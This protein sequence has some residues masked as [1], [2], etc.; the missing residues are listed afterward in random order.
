[1]EVK[2]HTC[3][4]LFSWIYRISMLLFTVSSSEPKITGCELLE[5]ENL[6]CYWTAHSSGNTSYMMRVN[7]T[8]C[9][10]HIST[11]SCNTTYTQCFVKIGSVSHCFC[12]D[13][14]VFTSSISTRYPPYC[15]NG[16]NE[17]KLYPP[18]ITT[19]ATLP[20]NASCLKLEWKEPRSEY[21]P[22]EKKHRVLQI[23]YHTPQ[24]ANF[25]K[26]NTV[27]HDWQM[28][29]CG[30]Y[31]GTK[32]FVR[33]RAQDLR[34]AN[35]W[36]SWSG[37][38][39]AT[40][41]EAAPV[42]TPEL[43]RH[44]Q[45][46]DRSRQR[47]ITLLWKPLLW[48]HTNG[49][50]VR[51]AAACWN[52]PDSSYWDCGHLESYSTFCVLSVS[53]HACNCNLTAFNSAGKSPSAHIYI[54]GDRDA[55]L[56]PP[57]SI[58]VNSL[59]DFQLKVEWTATVRQSDSS[60]V[61]E[62]FPIPNNTVA[63]L[64]WKI[65]NSTEKS[66]IITGVYPKIP[67]NVSVRI[68][69]KNTA[70]AARFAIAFTRQGA[71]SA[72]PKLDVLQTSSND[73]T[74]NWK[75]VALEKLC[76]FIQ[77]Y[78]VIYKYNGKIKA[79]VLSGD[80]E[81]FSMKGLSPGQYSMCVK[82]HTLAGSAESLWVNVTVGSFHV[83]VMAIV[84]CAIGSLLALVILLSQ[85]ERIQQCLCPIVPNPSKSSLST[86]HPLCPHQ[87]KL[88]IVDF[89]PSSSLFE[90]LCIGGGITA[91]PSLHHHEDQKFKAFSV[92]TSK[93]VH[94][95]VLRVTEQTLSEPKV[96][97]LTS[98]LTTD[99]SYQNAV[100][101]TLQYCHQL[102]SSCPEVPDLGTPPTDSVLNNSNIVPSLEFTYERLASCSE[103]YV[104][105][106]GR[107]L[108]KSCL[109]ANTPDPD[110]LFNRTSAV[111]KL[112]AYCYT[113]VSTSYLPDADPYIDF[114]TVAENSNN[115]IQ[116]SSLFSTQESSCYSHVSASYLPVP[117]PS[118]SYTDFVTMNKA[119]FLNQ[120]SHIPQ[121]RTHG[122]IHVSTSY[123]PLSLTHSEAN[124]TDSIHENHSGLKS[125]IYNHVQIS[126]QKSCPDFEI[127]D[128]YRSL[129]PEECS[130]S[131]QFS[132][133]KQQ[134]GNGVTA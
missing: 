46:G 1:M 8:N 37:F 43:W 31:P 124:V 33:V 68:L 92:Q 5:H 38:A 4:T 111:S 47:R 19:L 28:D 3:E 45:P 60:F 9:V 85:A 117:E 126:Y 50:I 118:L 74:L 96:E 77:N 90:P 40:T 27:L 79:Q 35:H 14:L 10:Q 102:S 109:R 42:A 59:D 66:F 84:L 17:V 73:V 83:P 110:N 76:G 97:E 80:V 91:Q 7:T 94:K 25:P 18:Q 128:V 39:E 127:E 129:S 100:V 70:G 132:I 22:S 6:T 34:A 26:V 62:W 81:Q 49:M 78:T 16:I 130:H 89:K 61:V 30:L 13:V 116:K 44:I 131:L 86:W 123:L 114:R 121:K 112:K 58:S 11:A 48:P 98:G 15:F 69:Q 134:G 104:S 113:H 2:K 51:Y 20:G 108:S 63:G 95:Q 32:H 82:A 71:P 87:H 103:T 36:S 52:E 101:E 119:D 41:A 105:S 75:P 67:Y 53:T 24:Q 88:P 125:C 107:G 56:Q 57:E 122:Y 72:G 54:P 21:V 93:Q 23:E 55:E 65:L 99:L 12:V 64:H 29:L 133:Q 106:D 120:S 115:L